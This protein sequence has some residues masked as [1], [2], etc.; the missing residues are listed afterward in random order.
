MKE[1]HIQLEPSTAAGQLYPRYDEE[2]NLLEVGSRVPRDWPYGVDIDGRIIF[3]ID[4]DYILANFDLLIRRRLWKVSS[5]LEIPQPLRKSNIKFTVESLK[6]KSFSLP[7]SINTN[8]EKS[9]VQIL[10]GKTRD[11]ADWVTISEYCF[12]L[13]ADEKLKGFFILL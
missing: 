3:D 2:A 1:I 8:K 12:A 9:C 11:N 10:I 4:T 13:I 5:N 7:L 6:H